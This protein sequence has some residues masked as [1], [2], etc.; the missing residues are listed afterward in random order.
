MLDPDRQEILLLR[1]DA[2]VADPEILEA[3]ATNPELST[4]SRRRIREYREHLVRVERVEDEAAAAGEID[5]DEISDEEVQE[6]IEVA[7]DAPADGELETVTGLTESQLKTLPVPI[8]LKLARGATRA[9][10]NILVRDSNPQVATSVLKFNPIADS[11]IEQIAASRT[12]CDEVLDVIARDRKW[13]RKYP[14]VNTLVRNPRR[15][16]GSR[17][18]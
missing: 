10:R 8:R 18:G 17:S 15:P 16:W 4:Y 13:T 7:K 12:V 1:Q 14:I 9:L 3:L 2:I 11:E 5:I 6:A